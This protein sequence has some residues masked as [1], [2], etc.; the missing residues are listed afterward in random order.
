M[1]YK[2][3]DKLNRYLFS[4]ACRQ[5]YKSPPIFQS[6]EQPI[7]V[8][9][10]LQHKDVLMFLIAVKSFAKQ[11]PLQ[12]VIIINDGSLTTDDFKILKTHIP[13]SDIYEAS[14]FSEKNCP[15]GGC[16][17]RLL[18]IAYFSETYYVIQL[19]SDTLTISELN[20]VY[21]CIDTNTGFVIGTWDNQIIESMQICSE[22]VQNN[23]GKSLQGH[24]Q[25]VAEAYFSDLDKCSELN[26]VRGC[27][28]FAGFPKN[29][30]KKEFIIDFSTQIETL[31]GSKWREWGSEQVMSN[32]VVAN[33]E[34]AQVLPH[35]K[36]CDC[37]NI[38]HPETSF[39]HFI[40]DC[41][42]KSDLYSKLA[43]K[44]I[45]KLIT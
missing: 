21:Q 31:I 38:K 25:M 9:T 2:L 30:F 43:S 18:A 34:K 17:E 10:Q 11:V 37:N 12:K 39:I 1:L 28:G 27:A 4:K 13:I 15:K 45:T 26:Y 5:I 42:F 19:D 29:G 35:P 8:L 14:E 33:L 16:W 41:R 20:E 24:V 3:K 23:V 40:G 7:A 32:V 6:S 22:R 44:A 36:Y